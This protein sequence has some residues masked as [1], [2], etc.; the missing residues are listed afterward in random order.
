MAPWSQKW[1]HSKS[2]RSHHSVNLLVLL[3]WKQG[4]QDMGLLQSEDSGSPFHPHWKWNENWVPQWLGKAASAHTW[5]FHTPK[6]SVNHSLFMPW[7][8]WRYEY[9]EEKE[10]NSF[11]LYLKNS[12][13]LLCPKK[14][15]IY[16]VRGRMLHVEIRSLIT[17]LFCSNWEALSIS[18]L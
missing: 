18:K 8:T 4:R 1:C 9:M 11:C 12:T 10:K 6:N 5:G 14:G 7:W 15:L 13:L 2:I 16:S 17:E 3:S